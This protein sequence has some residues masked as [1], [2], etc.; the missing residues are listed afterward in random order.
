MS[1][2]V[3]WVKNVGSLFPFP[4]KEVNL[5]TV[6]SKASLAKDVAKGKEQVKGE[7]VGENETATS[8]SPLRAPSL[9]T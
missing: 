7:V 9:G 6:L 8:R 2:N 3:R 1:V 4:I 5:D